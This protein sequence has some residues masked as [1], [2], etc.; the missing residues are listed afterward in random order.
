MMIERLWKDD[1]RESQGLRVAYT[2]MCPVVA[3]DNSFSFLISRPQWRSVMSCQTN[4]NFFLS[5]NFPVVV[6]VFSTIVFR[7]R[8]TGFRVLVHGANR[9]IVSFC[10]QYDGNVRERKRRSRKLRFRKSQLSQIAKM[11]LQTRGWFSFSE[12]WRRNLSRKCGIFLN[13]KIK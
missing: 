1:G 7:L 11:S 5:N 10:A 2:P 13:L 9:K 4:R 8:S 6:I 12:I 3:L